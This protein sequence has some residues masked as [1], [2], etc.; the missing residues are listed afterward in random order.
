MV[1]QPRIARFTIALQMNCSMDEVNQAIEKLTQTAEAI[2]ESGAIAPEGATIDTHYP[3]GR[4][5][6]VYRRLKSR[7]AIFNVKRMSSEERLR[8]VCL[9]A[10]P[11]KPIGRSELEDATDSKK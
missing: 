1:R 5:E 6:R 4:S 7:Q 2:R 8:R 3:G 9:M 11:I 10:S